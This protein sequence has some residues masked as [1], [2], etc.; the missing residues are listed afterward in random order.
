V[1]VDPGDAGF[2]PVYEVSA[3]GRTRHGT[4]GP[5]APHGLVPMLN[6]AECEETGST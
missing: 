2:P 5:T 6:P 1:F 3:D 4:L